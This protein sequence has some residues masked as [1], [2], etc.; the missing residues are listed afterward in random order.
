LRLRHHRSQRLVLRIHLHRR[1]GDLHGGL[2]P[3]DLEVNVE[4][5]AP[6]HRQRHLLLEC[7]ETRG[8]GANDIIARQQVS[9]RIRSAGSCCRS[10]HRGG[11]RGPCGNCGVRDGGSG[12]VQYRPRDLAC[13]RLRKRRPQAER[14]EDRGPLHV[15]SEFSDHRVSP[16]SQPVGRRQYSGGHK[17]IQKCR[18]QDMDAARSRRMRHS[19]NRHP[20]PQRTIPPSGSLVSRLARHWPVDK[21]KK[22]NNLSMTLATEFHF[23][24]PDLRKLTNP[25]R[26]WRPQRLSA[27][28]CAADSALCCCFVACNRYLIFVYRNS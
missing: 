5:N 14:R 2:G 1:L 26:T 6:A 10:P 9:D 15:L 13:L 16:F 24:N 11:G 21:T 18:G 25:G 20:A 22:T 23:L 12:W 8:G 19:K 17:R 3:A 4:A 27:P 28:I 7:S